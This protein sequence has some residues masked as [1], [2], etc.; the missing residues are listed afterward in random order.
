MI[1]MLMT[2]KAAWSTWWRA[3]L[4]AAVAAGPCLLL[5]Y[6]QGADVTKNKAEASRAVAVAEALKTDGASKEV[7]AGER[8]ADAKA[9]A[10]MREELVNAVQD[11]PDGQPSARRVALGCE[12]LRQ[13]GRDVSDLPACS[14]PASGVQAGPRP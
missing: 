11:L 13:S 9:N 3:V 8:L 12:R 7:A 2:A 4:G 5:G 6:C 10:A 14:R 1:E